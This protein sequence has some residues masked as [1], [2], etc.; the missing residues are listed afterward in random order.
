MYYVHVT[1]RQQATALVVGLGS[2]SKAPATRH[3]L[4]PLLLTRHPRPLL[5]TRASALAHACPCP[6]SPL[7]VAHGHARPSN[8]YHTHTQIVSPDPNWACLG[9]KNPLGDLTQQ[10]SA[11]GRWRSRECNFS[12]IHL[13]TQLPLMHAL[14]AAIG[15]GTA[16]KTDTLM[17]FHDCIFL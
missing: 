4:A 10:R 3:S 15:F 11:F 14:G 12:F 16:N 2:S 17:R 1:G 6:R 5:P 7:P 8:T 13:R 9:Q